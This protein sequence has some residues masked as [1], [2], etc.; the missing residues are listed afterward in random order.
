MNF[1][2][3]YSAD[4]DIDAA[5][6]NIEKDLTEF[7][8]SAI[9]YFSSSNYSP[10]ILSGKMQTAF[11]KKPVFGCTTSGEII[12]GKMLDNSIVAM[13]FNKNAV[14]DIKIELLENI[15]SDSKSAVEKA[16]SAFENYYGKPMLEIDPTKYIGIILVDGLSG[17]EER[18]ME[19]IGD[20]TNITFIGGSAGD[21]LKFKQT[22][23]FSNG[24]AYSNAALLIL[25][26]TGVP[27]DILKTQ[28]FKPT[29]KTLIASR[30]NEAAREVVEFNN[31]PA[32]EAYA[33]AV[34]STIEK[35]ADF[36]MSNPV[37]LMVG[38]EPYVRS[39]QQVKDK[40]MIFYC[41]VHEGTELKLLQSMD[42][43]EAT[44]MALEA[45]QKEL[46]TIS[47]IINFNCILRTLE[48]KQKNETEAYG[49][50]FKDYPTIGFS[51]YGE[52]LIG[53]INQT[54]TMLIFK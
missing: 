45:K 52:E 31:R 18:L 1:K 22:H 42:I 35:S 34:G 47:G 26:K 9:L 39:P 5:V 49:Q 2:T 50:L 51:T 15:N 44:R 54:A 41:N 25:I 3:S 10:E 8:P 24:K 7:Q 33:S 27:F 30:V 11:G 32:V 14:Q 53:H 20:L 19:R 48:L 29:D 37:G 23:V 6:K 21:D 17:A 40:S 38:D 46:G 12:T 4:Q 16:F 13:G 43:V 28:S 36:F